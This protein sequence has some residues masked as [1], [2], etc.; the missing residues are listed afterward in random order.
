MSSLRGGCSPKENVRISLWPANVYAWDKAL[1][2]QRRWWGESGREPGQCGWRGLQTWP[3][4]KSWKPVLHCLYQVYNITVFCAW[5][6]IKAQN[7]VRHHV[8]L[9]FIWLFSLF[10]CP[11]L[12]VIIVIRYIFLKINISYQRWLFSAIKRTF[13]HFAHFIIILPPETRLIE[14]YLKYV[15]FFL[16]PEHCFSVCRPVMAERFQISINWKANDENCVS[17]SF[18][19]E[20]VDNLDKSAHGCSPLH[21][22]G[23]LLPAQRCRDGSQ[24]SERVGRV[25]LPLLIIRATSCVTVRSPPC[26]SIVGSAAC[27][28]PSCTVL[29]ALSQYHGRTHTYTYTCSW[30]MYSCLSPDIL[31]QLRSLKPGLYCCTRLTVR[32][33]FPAIASFNISFCLKV[34]LIV[35]CHTWDACQ[36]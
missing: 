19:Q 11:D 1:R 3:W 12:R 22:L 15:C 4:P 29:W 6:L 25:N 8:N 18:P 14:L 32:N 21:S 27:D 16:F 13:Q 26:T 23:V 20:G 5:P 35:L 7:F 2:K 9:S 10:C 33:S 31:W 24:T 17:R 36:L 30:W 34:V 28:A